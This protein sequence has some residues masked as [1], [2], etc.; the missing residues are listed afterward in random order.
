MAFVI[1]ARRTG[2][3]AIPPTVEA[4]GRTLVMLG[5]TTPTS[6]FRSTLGGLESAAGIAAGARGSGSPRRSIDGLPA[7]DSRWECHSPLSST[8]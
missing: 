7:S 4:F 8:L 5:S 6:A 1:G 3:K 2:R